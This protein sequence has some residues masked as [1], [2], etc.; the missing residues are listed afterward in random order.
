MAQ[1]T[2]FAYPRTHFIIRSVFLFALLASMMV[3]T[4]VFSDIG[5]L[6]PSL[7]LFI[8]TIFILLTNVSPIF[9]RHE[10]TDDRIIL[11]NGIL[12]TG[13]F[14]ID[15]IASVTP[16]QRTFRFGRIKLASS[17]SNL[18]S[19]KLKSK[20]RFKSILF[21]TSDEMIIDLIRPD[22]FVHL[23][24]QRLSQVSLSPIQPDG[25]GPQLGD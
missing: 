1:G 11:R 9:T 6:W 23:A 15:E 14:T 12:F 13:S 16:S 19:I 18:V 3:F 21:R 24:N 25:P 7:L 17:T 22:E 20:R 10:I 5:L 4:L 8:F 2:R